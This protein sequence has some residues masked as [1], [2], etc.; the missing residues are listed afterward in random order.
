MWTPKTLQWVE[1]GKILSISENLV[2]KWSTSREY[3]MAGIKIVDLRTDEITAA[4]QEFWGRCV[5]TWEEDPK[6][7]QRQEEFWNTFEEWPEYAKYHGERHKSARAGAA[8]LSSLSLA[9]IKSVSVAND[10]DSIQQDVETD[11]PG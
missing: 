10:N 11:T 2:N 9:A 8:W 3:D 6:D 4:V 1:T 7:F 5:G